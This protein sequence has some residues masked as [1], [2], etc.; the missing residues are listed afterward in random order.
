MANVIIYTSKRFDLYP[1]I[2]EAASIG[3]PSGPWPTLP[4][5]GSSP[6]RLKL[7]RRRLFDRN[8][9]LI[10]RFNSSGW[11]NSLL[12]GLAEI[13][14]QRSELL[15][16]QSPSVRGACGFVLGGDPLGIRSLEI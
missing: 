16:G 10:S 14:T 9:E 3:V 1:S 11:F 4:F 12:M 5:D 6:A 7:P 2:T 8:R 15:E 13:V